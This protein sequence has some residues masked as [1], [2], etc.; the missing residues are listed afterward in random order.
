MLNLVAFNYHS[1]SNLTCNDKFASMTFY[2]ENK[3]ERTASYGKKNRKYFERDMYFHTF[4]K[5]GTTK[6]PNFHH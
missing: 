2:Y 4:T 5:L 3:T 1:N 6:E